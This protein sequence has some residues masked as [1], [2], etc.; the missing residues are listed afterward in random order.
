MTEYYKIGT[1]KFVEIN[2]GQAK[3]FLK[4]ELQQQKA[5]IRAR[6]DAVSRP[7]NAELLDWAKQNHPHFFSTAAEE[8]ELERINGVLD[9]INNL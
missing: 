8:A 2:G 7:S 3:V 5:D 1:G 4:S 6:L 9:I